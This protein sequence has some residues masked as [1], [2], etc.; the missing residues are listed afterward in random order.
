MSEAPPDSVTL[1]SL[2]NEACDAAARET[3]PRFR[4]NAAVDNKLTAGFDPVTEADQA[5]EAA[6]RTV[7]EARYPNHD[8]IGEEHGQ[9]D[10][11][12]LFQWIIDPIDGTRAFISGIPVWGTLIGLYHDGTPLAGV[13]DQPFT[14]ERFLSLPENREVATWLHYADEKP[15]RLKTR[16]TA[17]LAQAT[18]MTTTPHILLDIADQPYFRLE[19]KVK[20]FRYGCD[21]YAYAMVA[22]GQV[23]LVAESGL[24][25]YDIAALIPIIK[26][27]GGVVTNWQGGSAVQGG[28]ILAAA[29]PAIHKEAMDVLNAP[30]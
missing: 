1:R 23:D 14:R 5:A 22:A 8:I 18:L 3:L 2:L 17:E 28:Q 4:S 10:K 7:I 25:I 11:G 21:C 12:S 6:I 26:G 27:A 16:S 20:L 15:E 13:L 19:K 29:N 24:N 9:T 30:D